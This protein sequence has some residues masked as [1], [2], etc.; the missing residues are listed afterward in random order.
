M[1]LESETL[2]KLAEAAKQIGGEAFKYL[3]YRERLSGIMG[4]FIAVML[5]SST[6]IALTIT[7]RRIRRKLVEFKRLAMTRRLETYEGYLDG[8]N[9]AMCVATPLISIIS[10]VIFCDSC[11]SF[12][13][14]EGSVIR[15]MF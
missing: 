4:M 14:P 12:F 1:N 11:M 8:I 10:L 15:G 5:V 6:V 7:K 13:A 3:V 9:V 2:L